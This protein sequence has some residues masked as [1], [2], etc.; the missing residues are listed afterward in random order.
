MK[1]I[2]YLLSLIWRLWFL[3]IFITVFILLI[4]L[5]FYFTS[6]KKNNRIVCH[7]TRYWSKI[8]LYLSLIF[9]KIE[10]EERIKNSSPF[11]F[12]PN[13]VSTLYIPF[14]LAVIPFPLQFMGKHE[15][16]KIPLFGYFFYKNSVIVNR[17]NRKESYLAY[18]KAKET[19]NSGLNMCIFPEGG[20][21]KSNVFLKK[22]KN[23]P[24]KLA[25][26][27]NIKIVPITIADN[28]TIFPQKYY[29][30]YPGFPRIKIHKA[31]KPN[32]IKKDCAKNLNILVY[33]IIFEQLKHYE[34]NK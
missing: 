9:P 22:F 15:I 16:A 6:I 13:H 23:G 18:L 11:I 21:P 25:I 2:S 1:W 30:G 8:T 28:K 5:L 32:I 12:C 24:F 4:P 7:I 31:I 26:Q 27:N 34:S 17:T 20:I 29:K 10:W 3:I 19:I 14:I 33:N